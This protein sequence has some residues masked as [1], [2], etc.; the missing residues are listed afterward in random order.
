MASVRVLI[1]GDTHY[2]TKNVVETTEF[3]QNLFLFLTQQPDPFDFIVCTG[4]MLNDHETIHSDPLR[5]VIAFVHRLRQYAPVYVIVGNHD[6]PN[7]SNFLTD[8]HPFTAMKYW[9]ANTVDHQVRVVDVVLTEQVKGHQFIFVPYVPPGRFFDALQTVTPTPSDN[10]AETTG[11]LS[12]MARYRQRLDPVMATTTGLFTHQE[13]Y[14]VPLSKDTVSTNGDRWPMDYPV[15][16]NGHIHDYSQPQANVYN[17]GTPFQQTFGENA[18]KTISVVTFSGTP[19]VAESTENEV[20]TGSTA[21]TSTGSTGEIE[22]DT[23]PLPDTLPLSDEGVSSLNPTLTGVTVTVQRIDLGLTKKVT[24]E[25]TVN[26]LVTYQPPLGVHLKVVIIGDSAELKQAS[27]LHQ[28]KALI[29]RGV[30]V[31][32]KDSG[33]THMRNKRTPPKVTIGDQGLQSNISFARRLHQR[34]SGDTALT[35]LFTELFGAP[36]AYVGPLNNRLRLRVVTAE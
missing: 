13:F 24:V 12:Q 8:E 9:H 31:V 10:G 15:V 19:A 36:T 2:K 28:V 27:K 18:D 16:I 21:T 32:Y 14:G 33:E 20:T 11:T 6:R 30:R 7:N 26:D 34:V 25:L 23:V 22:S 29:D 4:D 17:V 35:T 3:E 5:R 1:I